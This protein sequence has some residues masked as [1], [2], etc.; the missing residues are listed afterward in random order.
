MRFD[1]YRYLWPPRPETKIPSALI[2][3]YEQRGWQAQVK[4][5]GTC[6]VVFARG[7]EVIFKT[8]HDDD[9][10]GWTPRE[11]HYQF[12]AGRPNWDVYVGELL[13]SRGVGIKDHLYLFDVL[14]SNGEDLSGATHTERQALLQGRFPGDPNRIA[15]AGLGSIYVHDHLSRVRCYASDFWRVWKSLGTHDEGL[16]FKNPDAPLR[17]CVTAKAN[18]A[19]QVKCRRPTANYSF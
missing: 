3:F 18:A 16:V 6:T 11:E 10:K 8:R 19:W 2:G 14:V 7:D 1:S 17:P 5:N 15:G 9:H 12:F 4:K 13:H